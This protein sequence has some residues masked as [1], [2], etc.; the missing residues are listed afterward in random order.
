MTG[1]FSPLAGFMSRADYEATCQSMRLAN[2]LVW[3]IPIVLDVHEDLARKLQAA[4]ML[5]LRDPEGRLLAALQVDDVWAREWAREASD[6]YGTQDT[7]HPGVE[8][9]SSGHPFCVG[10]RVIGLEQPAHYDFPALR[11]T[12]AQLRADFA[13]DSWSTRRGVPDAQPDAPGA[14]RADLAGAGG[15]RRR[16]A[17]D[18]PGGRHDQAGRRRSL[19]SGQVLPIRAP[20]LPDRPREAGAAPARDADGG[21]ARS[22]VARDH[23]QKLRLYA[24]DRR[25]RSRRT[26]T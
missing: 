3:P 26:R 21:P 13:A 22:G 24:P 17:A 4:A 7:L 11:R 9:L 1:A 2:G 18:S 15:N 25:P 8:A 5:A 10:G 19:H 14:R 23:P 20:G 6:V 16:T 12:P